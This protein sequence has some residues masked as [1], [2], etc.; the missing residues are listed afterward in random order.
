MKVVLHG[1]KAL[2][3][4]LKA[5]SRG[6]K[7]LFHGLK[8]LFHGLKALFHGLKALWGIGLALQLSACMWVAPLIETELFAPPRMGI[9]RVAVMSFYPKPG[10]ARTTSR[11]GLSSWEAAALVTRFVSEA[12]GERGVEA[13]PV[14]ELE[15][16]LGRRRA[17][18]G[19]DAEVA[20]AAVARGFDAGG[21]LVGEVARY[22]E[23][24]GGDRGAFSSASVAFD[25]TLY[26]APSGVKLWRARFDQTQSDF[27]SNPLK[28][29]HYPGRG[30][31]FLTAAELVRWGAALA[32]KAMPLTG[33]GRTRAGSSAPL[34]AV[35]H[36]VPAR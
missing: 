22:R 4:G 29:A 33:L 5:L 25:L 3:D 23:R 15:I 19:A 35:Q 36:P 10:L 31:R 13:I 8:A 11:S 17:P 9:D 18:S 30:T 16:A 27:S 14:S 7:A 20:A 2:F 26:E 28:A 6:L 24:V 34:L 1:L 32:A 21:L 12:I